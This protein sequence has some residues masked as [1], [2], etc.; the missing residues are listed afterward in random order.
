MER[1]HSLFIWYITTRYL[2]IG[3][4]YIFLA[5]DSRKYWSFSDISPQVVG[6]W[7]FSVGLI[8][9]LSRV[10]CYNCWT[11]RAR[12]Y[13]DLFILGVV[14]HSLFRLTGF[15]QRHEIADPLA[16]LFICDLG[17]MI[18]LKFQLGKWVYCNR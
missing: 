16:V 17:A 14:S 6:A 3:L 7:M 2:I 1:Y 4:E 18:W 9:L 8:G 11:R 5:E 12:R 10:A 13:T 15:V